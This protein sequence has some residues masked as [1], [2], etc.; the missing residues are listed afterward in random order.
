[1]ADRF[2]V[3]DDKVIL[4]LAQS[5]FVPLVFSSSEAAQ[6]ACE[7][8]NELD[9]SGLIEKHDMSNPL[10]EAVRAGTKVL[11]AMTAPE[12]LADPAQIKDAANRLHE[13]AGWWLKEFNIERKS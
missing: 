13:A 11:H 3:H 6:R 12:L 2:T 5:L 10:F 7:V 9:R 1:M 4:D 8:L